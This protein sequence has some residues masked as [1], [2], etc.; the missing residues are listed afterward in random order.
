MLKR[1][2]HRFFVFCLTR[3]IR[4]GN[5]IS[6]ENRTGKNTDV[7]RVVDDHSTDGPNSQIISTII[8]SKKKILTTTGC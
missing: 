2:R 6:I 8:G 3:I 1:A 5:R 7:E 4:R